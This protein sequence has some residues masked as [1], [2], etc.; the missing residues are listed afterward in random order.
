V[1]A[2]LPTRNLSSDHSAKSF[3]EKA[4]ERQGFSSIFLFFLSFS[5]FLLFPNC[6][7]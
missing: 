7:R 3:H 1:G 6:S 2:Q 4:G 5:L